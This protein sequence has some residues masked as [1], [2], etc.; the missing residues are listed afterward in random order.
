M[1]EHRF[2]AGGHRLFATTW[3]DI[4]SDPTPVVM[5]HGGLDC[6][7]T[8]KDLPAAI[9]A[10]TG[11]AVLSYDRYGYGKSERLTANRGREYRYEEAGP[12]IRDLLRHFGLRRA[13]LFGHSDGG[14]IAFLAA[15]THPTHIAGVCACAPTIALDA[16]MVGA[17]ARTL[18][19]FESGGLRERLE[20]HHGEN[21]VPMYRSWYAAWADEQ[22]VNWSMR[23]E[24][25]AIRC[26]AFA[27]FGRD[28]EYGW[29]A[30]LDAIVEHCRCALQVNVLPGVGH[31]PQQQARED[32]LA[33]LKQ[34][35]EGGSADR[36][37]TAER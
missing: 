7:S 9:H 22:A 17:T 1:K 37:M 5:L 29:R 35:I 14:A 16:A 8:W 20:R 15:A 4:G 27:V 18:R 10:Q 21:T 36:R 32:V 2:S 31:H 24:L 13:V 33:V 12:V 25:A 30:S 11:H 19:A 26:P 6:T 23:D 34:C 28:D 3:G